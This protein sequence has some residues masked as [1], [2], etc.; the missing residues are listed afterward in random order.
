MQPFA[1]VFSHCCT[2][3]FDMNVSILSEFSNFGWVIFVRE[4]VRRSM[5]EAQCSV[6][7][8]FPVEL[9]GPNV[10]SCR[11]H[12]CNVV[13]LRKSEGCYFFKNFFRAIE[14]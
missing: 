5:V 9:N 14:L 6:Q 4:E 2:E 12:K 8:T 11:L 13:F 1:S 3:V 10:V 7:I